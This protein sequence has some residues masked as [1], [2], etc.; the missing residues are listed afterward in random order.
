LKGGVGEGEVDGSKR[1]F[2][3]G[4]ANVE[5]G[6]RLYMLAKGTSAGSREG[7]E[8]GR[9]NNERGEKATSESHD[10][11]R[12]CC[13]AAD[14]DEVRGIVGSW[15]RGVCDAQAQFRALSQRVE[16]PCRQVDGHSSQEII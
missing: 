11:E 4:C 15:G 9:N 5:E 16:K 2:I 12:I 6:P 1:I 13:S 14:G 8:E 3:D 10:N 7:E